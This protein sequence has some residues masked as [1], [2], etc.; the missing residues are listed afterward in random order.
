MYVVLRLEV[1]EEGPTY[2]MLLP[3][4]A[5]G[6][7]VGHKTLEPLMV[8]SVVRTATRAKQEAVCHHT[9]TIKRHILK[10]LN[11][12]RS[13]FCIAFTAL[14]LWHFTPSGHME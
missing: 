12:S 8:A 6:E 7:Y 5:R 13:Q 2:S 1:A 14:A 11:I 3:F 9:A 10:V 4:Q